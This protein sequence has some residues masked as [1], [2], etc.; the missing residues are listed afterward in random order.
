MKFAILLIKGKYKRL[1]FVLCEQKD[2]TVLL[3]DLRKRS[4]VRERFEFR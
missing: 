1:P 4:R 3:F 2:Q